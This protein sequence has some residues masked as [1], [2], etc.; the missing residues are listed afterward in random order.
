M[1][2]L[3]VFLAVCF[4]ISPSEASGK[5]KPKVAP[6]LTK[7][8]NVDR[9]LTYNLGATGLRGWI[10]TRPED[11]FESQQGRTTTKS[12]QILVTHVGKKSPAEGVIKV[13]DV[14]L[15]A[16]GK[17]F[18]DDARISIALA[19]QEAEK[20]IIRE[21]CHSLSGEAERSKI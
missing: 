8:T 5:E 10:F 16:G 9:E 20:K 13:D 2:S 12:R 19:I 11:Y 1:K 7:D 6:D 21:F 17:M 14:I 4:L 18:T 15:G 3:I